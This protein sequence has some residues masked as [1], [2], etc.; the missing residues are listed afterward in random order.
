M[1]SPSQTTC[2]LVTVM[3]RNIKQSPNLKVLQPR[4]SE[5]WSQHGNPNFF[6]QSHPHDPLLPLATG[7]ALTGEL[8][9]QGTAGV[10]THPSLSAK[11]FWPRGAQITHIPDLA[12][13]CITI[14]LEFRINRLYFH[15]RDPYLPQ[16]RFPISPALIRSHNGFPVPAMRLRSL[17]TSW[18]QFQFKPNWESYQSCML[19]RLGKKN[20]HCHA[21][22]TY[23]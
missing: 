20:S 15:L 21:T 8:W 13:S 9:G 22:V 12:C 17:C 14:L 19:N 18:S 10:Q 16:E 6:T 7:L 3:E 4:S 2:L 11:P 1:D 5:T 23:F